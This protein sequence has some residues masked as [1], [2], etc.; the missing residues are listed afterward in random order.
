MLT[1]VDMWFA[2]ANGTIT[3][4]RINTGSMTAADPSNH[5]WLDLSRTDVDAN[6]DPFHAILNG[7]PDSIAAWVK[8]KQNKPV[9]DFPYATISAVITDG[10]YYQDPEDNTCRKR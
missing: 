5:S 10:T 3:T 9:A 2:I 4:G 8:F 6:G 1:S 7:Q